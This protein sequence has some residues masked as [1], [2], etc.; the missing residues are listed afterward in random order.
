M[1]MNIWNLES[2]AQSS[3]Y[4]RNLFVFAS[5]LI[6]ILTIY[7]NTF[8]AS[9]QFDDASNIRDRSAVHMK[10]L[11]WP[12]IKRSLFFGRDETGP[13]PPDTL[14]RPVANFSFALNYYF[15]GLNVFGYHVVNITVHVVAAMFLFLFIFHTLNLP[16][17]RPRYGQHSYFIALLA[18][19][20]WA[21]NPVQT[22]AVTY[23][24]QRMASMSAM[25][26]IMSMYFFAKARTSNYKSQKGFHLGM[27]FFSGIFAIGSKENAVTL[28]I[29]ILTYDLFFIQGLTKKNIK[30][31]VYIL[32]LLLAIP[33]VFALILKGPSVFEPD[34]I[35]KQYQE[36]R[37]FTLTER[38]LTEPRIILWYISL[39]FYPM[40]QRLSICHDISISHSLIDPP[41]TIIAILIILAVL[42]LC[43]IKAIRWPLIT[44][45]IF[46]FFLNHVIE[47][48][49]FG[50]EL[51]FEHRNYLPSM[52][53]FV[54]LAVLLGKG[55]EFYADK[56]AMQ[57]IL[58]VFVILVLVG[59]GNSTFMRNYIWKTDG[60]LW[61]DA[62]EKAPELVRPH[63]NLG[64]YFLS[65]DMTEKAL[66][67]FTA[68]ASGKIAGGN[69][70]DSSTCLY[71]VGI[72]YHRN[73]NLDQALEY[74]RSA[75]ESSP[76][77]FAEL[78]NN[79]GLI[80]DQKGQ[81]EK[82]EQAFFDALQ[83]NE[84]FIQPYRNLSLAMIKTG[85]VEQALKHLNTALVKWPED[86]KLLALEGYVQRFLGDYAK[87]FLLFKRAQ[88]I[89][90]RDAKICLYLAELY[91]RRDMDSKAQEQIQQFATLEKTGDLFL[92]LRGI[93]KEDK[94]V[95]IRPFKKMV[96]DHLVLAYEK[97]G[98]LLKARAK[99]L[100][101]EV[102]AA[103]KIPDSINSL[104]PTEARPVTK[105]KLE[106]M[107]IMDNLHMNSKTL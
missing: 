60:T 87:A 4:R 103:C 95:G 34:K 36:I 28:P 25:F 3:P 13:M 42:G 46:F 7:S 80:Y 53:L 56:Q 94:N 67:E 106:D 51:I 52:L 90:P 11:T 81:I 9:W 73:G 40:S 18:T 39:L 68:G 70:L 30:K 31:S 20:F 104:S 37:N 19:A 17:L 29:A 33:P 98:E 2:K 64:C 5:L 58:S 50:L 32:F 10:Q 105:G 38:L 23:I 43:M 92:Y 14:Y 65:H 72:V 107:E 12:S 85:Q 101:G 55:I 88:D 99:A 86:M 24:V 82:A 16:L 100:R 59:F 78:H 21:I 63:L 83:C 71:D 6:I 41:T 22:Q 49:I 44:Y 45:C 89:D 102:E 62:V 93:T 61:A 54:P 66:A 96:M 1:N 47:G 75:L 91:F 74:Y 27:C 48:S 15:G 97:R 84:N 26:Y 35:L 8:D 77:C 69:V 79:M 57:L 76:R